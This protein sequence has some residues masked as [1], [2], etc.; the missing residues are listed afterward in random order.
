M[1]QLSSQLGFSTE[2]AR[3]F[4]PPAVE[5]VLGVV[6]GGG[7]VI[8]GGPADAQATPQ[9][10]AT[11]PKIPVAPKPPAW[12]AEQR[13]AAE[14]VAFLRTQP[15]G[16]SPLAHVAAAPPK[17]DPDP[18]PVRTREEPPPDVAA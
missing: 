13:A 18:E 12:S 7:L 15:F 9:P 5:Q 16:P 2:Q 1:E 4:V 14:R 17:Q 11:P 8:G 6:K 3:G 10:A